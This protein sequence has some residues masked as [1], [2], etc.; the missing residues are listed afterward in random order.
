MILFF[1]FFKAVLTVPAATDR[2]PPPPPPLLHNVI[3]EGVVP[4]QHRRL[5]C[6][7]YNMVAGHC[8]KGVDDWHWLQYIIITLPMERER[9]ESFNWSLI[10]RVCVCSLNYYSNSASLSLSL[11]LRWRRFNTSNVRETLTYGVNIT[12]LFVKFDITHI[13]TLLVVR[14]P[15][16]NVE[17]MLAY[18]FF[19]QITVEEVHSVHDR[20]S[21]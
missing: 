9:A 16:R 3:I 7:C 8:R 15:L 20:T 17:I 13:Q 14:T 1:F 5:Y 19:L 12:C 10:Y 11:T 4:I 18:V 6:C 2:Q 21:V